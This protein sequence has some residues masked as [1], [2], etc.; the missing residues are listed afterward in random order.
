MALS[1][2]ATWACALTLV[3]PV[4]VCAPSV[5][6]QSPASGDKGVAHNGM[7]VAV[8]EEPPWVRVGPDPVRRLAE[9]TI[10]FAGDSLTYDTWHWGALNEAARVRGWRISGVVA[11][12][13]AQ[14]ADIARQW[15]RLART[16]PGA[17]VIALGTND[18]IHDTNPTVFRRTIRQMVQ[19]SGGRSVLLVGIS[20]R[21]DPLVAS[22]E[23]ALNAELRAIARAHPNVRFAAWATVLRRHPDWILQQDPF[24][25][26]LTDA[27][28]RGRAMFYIRALE[29][30]SRRD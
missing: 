17:V 8:R 12:A 30:W 28:L 11:R 18:V 29:P 2:A 13:G 20:V 19:L 5:N 24:A 9:D 22:R 25:V 14:A 3:A 1:G 10:F 6:A 23:A 21:S 16:L 4:A 27:G 7:P 15:P 26:H